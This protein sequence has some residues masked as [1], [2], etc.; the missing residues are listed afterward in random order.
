MEHN[1]KDVPAKRSLLKIEARIRKFVKYYIKEA[2]LP[3]DWKYEPSKVK[4]LLH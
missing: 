1:K 3:K 2:K 4:L